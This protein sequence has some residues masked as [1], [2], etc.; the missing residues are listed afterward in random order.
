MENDSL[1]HMTVQKPYHCNAGWTNLTRL[2]KACLKPCHG[3]IRSCLNK[4][5]TPKNPR[6]HA[7][8]DPYSPC[9]NPDARDTSNSRTLSALNSLGCPNSLDRLNGLR[10]LLLCKT[11]WIA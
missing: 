4:T 7:S 6:L 8:R 3:I 9:M 1:A 5:Q 10:S 11:S 2:R